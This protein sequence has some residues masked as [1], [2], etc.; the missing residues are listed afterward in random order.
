M[1]TEK[2]AKVLAKFGYT[3]Q[4]MYHW[5]DAFAGKVMRQRIE[6]AKSKDKKS[7]KKTLVNNEQNRQQ[8][9]F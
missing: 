3:Y 8:K 2:Q 1:T 7:I 9:L 6:Y 5:S 4:E